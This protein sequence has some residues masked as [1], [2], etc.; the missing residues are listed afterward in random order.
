M[1]YYLDT[2][3]FELG[4]RRGSSWFGPLAIRQ[5]V[6]CPYVILGDV[7]ASVICGAR[8]KY[9]KPMSMEDEAER[10]LECDSILARARVLD[11]RGKRTFRSRQ[12]S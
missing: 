5:D 8:V 2:M 12:H 9:L 3:H 6:R 4:E 11:G 7:V 10:Q 1:R